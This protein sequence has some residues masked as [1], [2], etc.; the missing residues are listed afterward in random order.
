MAHKTPIAA[1]LLSQK[2]TM[3]VQFK[4][5]NWTKKLNFEI[6]D[7]EITAHYQTQKIIGRGIDRIR[8]I[9]LE[10]AASELVEKIFCI[11]NE[12][13]SIGLAVSVNIDAFEH[14]R[15]E[16]LER[17]FLKM[18]LES[19]SCFE[20][21]SC[22]ANQGKIVLGGQEIKSRFFKF[23]TDANSIGILCRLDIDNRSDIWSYGISLDSSIEYAKSKALIEALPNFAHLLGSDTM[24]KD[25]TD[26]WQLTV[27]FN[28]KILSQKRKS[29]HP[30]YIQQP[31][32][33]QQQLL[34]SQTSI[35]DVPGFKAIKTT[36][37]LGN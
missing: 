17:Y 7:F 5:M 29:D 37:Y 26:I 34:Q 2:E 15:K 25:L 23:V 36:I 13:D 30:K 19:D 6:Y 9:A 28:N 21:V 22:E 10:K 12:I 4:E 1:W 32:F 20:Q 14:S 18:H 31:Q 8:E 35:F 33:K 3:D 16:A 27:D 11:E 24:N